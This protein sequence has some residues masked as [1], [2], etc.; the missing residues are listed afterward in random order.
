MLVTRRAAAF[1][2]SLPPLPLTC[3]VPTRKPTNDLSKVTSSSALPPSIRRLPTV[4][5]RVGVIK[6]IFP[7]I[8]R[9]R[10][11]SPEPVRETTTVLRMPGSCTTRSRR[12]IDVLTVAVSSSVWYRLW[13][14]PA[15]FAVLRITFV[16]L[17]AEPD[18]V[19][20]TVSVALA[21]W[22]RFPTFH[23]PSG[24]LVRLQRVPLLGVTDTNVTPLGSVKSSL[25][26]T[27][28]AFTGPRFV[29]VTRYVRFLIPEPA[30]TGFA[31]T[32]FTTSKSTPFGRLPNISGWPRT[33]S[34]R[35]SFAGSFACPV[36]AT[37]S[38]PLRNIRV[39]D[40]GVVAV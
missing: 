28:V 40:V 16:P 32:V 3:N 29:T 24:V 37:S 14:E 25:N 21:P 30:K 33:T 1:N 39:N 5:I 4:L 12:L 22:S 31:E 19:S 13:L 36:I 34:C 11:A 7:C 10:A 18:T 2:R 27:P 9:N 20:T 35:G 38:S 17:A 15:T 6:S 23:V 8:T 26:V